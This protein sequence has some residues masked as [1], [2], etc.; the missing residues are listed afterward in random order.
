MGNIYNWALR[1][2]GLVLFIIIILRS[3]A[4]KVISYLFKMN[5]YYFIAANALSLPFM[6]AK[7]LRWQIIMDALGIKYKLMDTILIYFASMF[8]GFFTPGNLGD[9]IKAIYLKNDG[10]PLGKSFASVLLDRLS[11]VISIIL[12]GSLGFIFL[13]GYAGIISLSLPLALLAFFLI[14][15]ICFR[16][17]R[18]YKSIIKS[19][20]PSLL[21]EIYIVNMVKGIRDFRNGLS[22]MTAKQL[23]ITTILTLICW[24][25]YFISIYFLALSINLGVPFLYLS[26]C[27]SISLIITLI[28]ITIAGIG[29]RDATLITLFSY[30]GYSSE[31]AVALSMTLLAYYL[32]NILICLVAWLIRPIDLSNAKYG[33]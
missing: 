7:S 11:D 32:V 19:W 2:L 33:A 14:S 30:L 12:L 21:P 13:I 5:L 28:P 23:I 25:I 29:T 17:N 4:D 16:K 8:I 24:A 27:I 18:G 31:S 26:I 3:D 9:F 22:A 20:L 6:I 15:V 10:H 1:S